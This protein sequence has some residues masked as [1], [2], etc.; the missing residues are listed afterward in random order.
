MIFNAYLDIEGSCIDALSVDGG[1][2]G[3][4][5]N[6][7]GTGGGGI[8]GV[9]GQGGYIL[10]CDLKN[11]SITTAVGIGGHSATPPSGNTGGIGGAGET[12][13]VSL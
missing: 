5:G 13:R 3:N 6:G 12:T 10:N 1:N 9:G 11:G 7:T 2:S 8:A 4:G